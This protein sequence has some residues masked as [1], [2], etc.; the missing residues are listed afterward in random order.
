MRSSRFPT[1]PNTPVRWQVFPMLWPYLLEFKGRIVVALLCLVGAKIATIGLPYVLKYT[2]DSLNAPSAADIAI[3]VVTALVIAYG[4]L[5]LINVLLSEVRDTLFGRVTERA[6]RRL[7]LAVFNH[8]HALDLRY[9]LN[10]QTG[11]L[12]RDIERGS[13]GVSFLMRFL[14]FNI[15]PT[16]IEIFIVAGLL[17]SQYGANYAVVILLSVIIY[18]AFSVVATNWRTN[19]VNEMNQADSASNSRA[20]DSLLNFETVKYFNNE[21]YEG[22]HYDRSLAHWETARRKNRLSLFAL[23]GGQALIIAIAMTA[24]MAMAAFDVAAEK[25][26]IGDFV[27]INAFTMQIFTPLNFLGFVYREIRGAIVNIDNLFTILQQRSTIEDKPDA[28]S[29]S[30]QTGALTFDKVSFSYDNQRPILKNVTFTVAP[31]QK[32]AIVGESGAGKSTIVKLLFRFYDVT[33][34]AISV[35]SADIRSVSQ[36]SLR[37]AFGVVPQDTVLFNDS[38]WENVKYG[39]PQASDEEVWHAIRQAQLLPFIETLPNKQNTK[40]G[41][42]GL[43]VSGGEKQRIAIARVLLKNP[44]FFLFDEATSSLDTHSEKRVMEAI[45]QVAKSTTTLIIAHRLST[46]VNAD[47]IIV[48]DNGEIAEQGTHRQ[49]LDHKGQYYR[50]WTAQLKES[51][52]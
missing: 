1:A 44:P 22:K 18:V 8:L 36:Q 52:H 23:N 7:G 2:V 49:L 48:L 11:G 46:I 14:V 9:H 6:M 26:T 43:K 51:T 20:I 30:V 10:R 27:L 35:D 41:E 15:V 50:L 29:L 40:V 19:F 25:M 38:I 47:N 12:A 34:G 37:Q 24:M 42:R 5:R 16:F 13:S 32:V 3:A 45:N 33:D 31:G 28:P 39:N 21:N 4:S 17:L